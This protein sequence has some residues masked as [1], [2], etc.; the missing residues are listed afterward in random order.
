MTFQ[1][2]P[3]KLKVDGLVDNG[4]ETIQD[5]F[6]KLLKEQKTLFVEYSNFHVLDIPYRVKKVHSN[7]LSH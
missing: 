7:T 4:H 6:A 2:G 5:T 1:H 3:I